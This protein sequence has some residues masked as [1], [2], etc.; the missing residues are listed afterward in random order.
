[1]KKISFLVVILCL[2]SQGMAGPK[3]SVSEESWDFGD[4]PAVG[5]VT[6]VYKL[7]NVGDSTLLIER[8][9]VSCGCTTTGVSKKELAPRETASVSVSFNSGLYPQGGKF[10]KEVYIFSNDKSA[11]IKNLTFSINVVP[12]EFDGV[13][14]EPKILDIKEKE[15]GREVKKSVVIK[16]K[17]T[18]NYNVEILETSGVIGKANLNEKVLK[19]NGSVKLTV[20]I[21]TPKID[22]TSNNPLV[23]DK[24]GNPLFSSVSLAF[25][26]KD[27]VKRITLPVETT[28]GEINKD[29]PAN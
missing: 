10:T 8:V 3:L 11:P 18:T 20:T 14:V 29:K 4:A 7:K 17:G 12:Q 15:R 9:D 26:G 25:K 28:V 19:G 21:R 1:M 16:N 24:A 27:T 23:L 2:V 13:S 6:H 5:H 22:A